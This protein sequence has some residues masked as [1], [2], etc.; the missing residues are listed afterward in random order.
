[1]TIGVWTV[2]AAEGRGSGRG[3]CIVFS[4]TGAIISAAIECA[5][6][7]TTGNGLLEMPIPLRI[8]TLMSM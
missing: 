8:N 5:W 4:S 7:P 6:S 1:M 2:V 3:P